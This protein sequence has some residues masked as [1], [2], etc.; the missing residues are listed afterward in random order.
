MQKKKKIKQS[1]RRRFKITKK[2][3]VLFARQNMGHLKTNKSKKAIR[4]NK[5][6]GNLESSFAKKVKKMLGAI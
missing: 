4:R 2:G 3:K 6:V 5:K 1:V